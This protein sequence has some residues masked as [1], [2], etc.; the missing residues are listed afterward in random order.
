[1]LFLSSCSTDDRSDE[2][3]SA[4]LDLQGVWKIDH[5]EVRAKNFTISDCDVTDQI[6]IN[7]DNRGSYL[8]SELNNSTNLCNTISNIAGQWNYDVRN[9]TLVL[10]YKESDIPKTK[11]FQIDAISKSEMRILNPSK[12]ISG[13]P[14]SNEV[15]EVWTKH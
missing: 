1:M 3:P 13:A 12:I 14:H 4:K 9:N 15:I 11:V 10:D 8:D 2:M 6:S 5:Y 7:S